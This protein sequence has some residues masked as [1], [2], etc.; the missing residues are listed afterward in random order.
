MQFSVGDTNHLYTQHTHA[1]LD[2]RRYQPVVHLVFLSSSEP[3]KERACHHI[4][5]VS[6]FRDGYFSK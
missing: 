2:V 1:P 3:F 6:V 4:G 5:L